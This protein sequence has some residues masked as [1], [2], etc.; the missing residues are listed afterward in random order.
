MRG[1][2][3]GEFVVGVANCGP[4]KRFQVGIGNDASAD[5]W[6]GLNFWTQMCPLWL[7]SKIERRRMLVPPRLLSHLVNIKR[8]IAAQA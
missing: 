4:S 8:V 6:L 3:V 2:S 1:S 5:V 7:G